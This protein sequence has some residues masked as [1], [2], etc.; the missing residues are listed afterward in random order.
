MR[1]KI[2]AGVVAGLIAG[3]VFGMMMQMMSTPTPQGGQMPMMQMV[4]MVVRSDSI[5]V[6]WL[7]HLF[8]SA[9][10]GAIFGLLL[11]SRA[12]SYGMGLGWGA[13]YG[14]IWWVLGAQILMPVSLGMQPFAS[15]MMA[16]MRMVAMGSFVGHILYGL[17]LGAGFVW[18]FKPVEIRDVESA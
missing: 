4:A 11:G 10:M 7:Y 3:V 12:Q 18:L 15:L 8:N 17:I 2:G 9:V 1:S 14:I 6:G 13:L 5:A 16:P